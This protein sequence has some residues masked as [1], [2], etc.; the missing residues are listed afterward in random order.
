MTSIRAWMSGRNR[1]STNVTAFHLGID[2][3]DID[4]PFDVSDLPW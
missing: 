2:I 1:R 3:R 4:E